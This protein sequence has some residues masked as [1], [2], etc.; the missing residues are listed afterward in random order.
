MSGL[1]FSV[2]LDQCLAE[3]CDDVVV[4]IH[5]DAERLAH[6]QRRPDDD[7]PPLASVLDLHVPADYGQWNLQTSETAARKYWFEELSA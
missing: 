5:H 4:I 1:E 2:G 3:V 6:N 7:V